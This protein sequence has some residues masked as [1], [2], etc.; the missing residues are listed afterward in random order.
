MKSLLLIPALGLA[1]F[2]SACRTSTPIDPN[3]LKPSERCQPEN[4][5]PMPTRGVPYKTIWQ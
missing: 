2:T 4:V 1:L 5:T 3:T